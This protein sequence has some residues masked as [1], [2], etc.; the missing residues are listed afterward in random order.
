MEL[1][2]SPRIQIRISERIFQIVST[3]DLSSDDPL[4]MGEPLRADE[5]RG[6]TPT[7][8]IYTLVGL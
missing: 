1:D 4:R 2:E 7:N 5:P 6:R 8:F 3:S